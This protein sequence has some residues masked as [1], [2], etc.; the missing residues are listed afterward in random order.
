MSKPSKQ[1]VHKAT[2]PGE[3]VGIIDSGKQITK[4]YKVKEDQ[5]YFL[6]IYQQAYSEY[7]G[8]HYQPEK[9]K[10]AEGDFTAFIDGLLNVLSK[11][12]QDITREEENNGH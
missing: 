4:F 3:L 8:Y 10:V 12:E 7:L 9:I 6:L 11:I 5:E 1:L 2:E